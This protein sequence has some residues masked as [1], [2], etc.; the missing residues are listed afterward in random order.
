M[1]DFNFLFFQ[2]WENNYCERIQINLQSLKGGGG[3]GVGFC[4]NTG[5]RTHTAAS[6]DVHMWNCT[7]ACVVIF[8]F[9]SLRNE[10]P[11]V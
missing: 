6:Q 1:P 5:C 9:I 10:V 8:N 4:A 11:K 7:D 3:G 2:L